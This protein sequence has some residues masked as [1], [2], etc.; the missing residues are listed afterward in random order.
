MG[1]AGTRP[2]GRPRGGGPGPIPVVAGPGRLLAAGGCNTR[3][4]IT[5]R[6]PASRAWPAMAARAR[7]PP[8]GA[9]A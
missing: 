3:V 6:A 2:R 9:S 1:R 4:V 5:R 7:I 8:R